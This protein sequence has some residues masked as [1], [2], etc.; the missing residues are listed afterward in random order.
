MPLKCLYRLTI[1]T[2]GRLKH[3][4]GAYKKK[5]DQNKALKCLNDAN[6]HMETCCGKNSESAGE[7]RKAFDELA[8]Q[9]GN[10][11][12]NPWLKLL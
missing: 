7:Y 3:L 10:G 8:K 5:G 4:R 1:F 2:F 6:K 12:V 11:P 9:T